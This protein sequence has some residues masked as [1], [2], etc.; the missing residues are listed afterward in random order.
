MNE[1]LIYH[2]VTLDKD[3][4]K[5]CTNCLKRCPTEAIR[6]RAGKA[7]ILR[8][9]CIDCGECIRVCPHH[10][11]KAV[12]DDFDE[13]MGRFRYRVALPAPSLYGQ[14]N[15]LDDIDYVLNGLIRI[16]FDNVLEVS[17]A[18]EIVSDYTRKLMAD[19][20]LKRPVVSSACPTIV[21]LISVRFP[22]LCSHVLPI[23]TPA[24]L[25]ARI[26]RRN[27][28]EET[29]LD[30]GEI[31]VFFLSPC[32]SK[33]AAA[34]AP[35][36]LPESGIDGVF[37]ISD[38]Y[39][40]LLPEMKKITRPQPLSHSGIM[41]IGWA[42]SGGEASALLG[43]RYLAADGIENCIK[44]L[45]E[46]EDGKLADIE[47]IELNACTGGC[48]GGV[49]AIE[50]P[51]VAK[52]RISFLRKY[53]PVARN[54]YDPEK[55]GD[56]A[57]DWADELHYKPVMKLSDDRAQALSMLAQID[58]IE[59]LL[60]GLDCGSCGSPTCRA[61]AE[62]IVRGY[63]TMDDCVFKFRERVA[64]LFLDGPLQQPEKEEESE[65]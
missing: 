54:K 50:N 32:P 17:H 43:E 20:S 16:G 18:A 39:M 4:C 28:V 52:T 49:L 56:S 13:M 45:E 62:D 8:E 48:V 57:I 15:N 29:G 24:E 1:N 41:G 36:V 7:R 21:K 63:G 9:L 12:Y 65:R 34:H 2:S 61:Q 30:P 60:P 25:A 26:A 47:F 55:M 22:E 64:G 6:V 46:L 31:G 37:A 40:R 35:L 42:S 3:K 27:A 11:K 38:I 44:V 33:V 53:L 58:R 14:F 10:A 51:F 23:L 19:R 59:K 5:G